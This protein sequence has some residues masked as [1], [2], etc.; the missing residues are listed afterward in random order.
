[1]GKQEYVQEFKKSL[2]II[3]GELNDLKNEVKKNN[4]KK[5]DLSKQFSIINLPSGGIYYPNRNKSLLIRYLTSVEEHILCDSLLMESGKGIE[6]VLDNLIM[7]D[8]DIRKLLVSDFQALLIFL[9]ST[10][11]GDAVSME[12]TCP[13]C[14]RSDEYTVRLSALKFK[15]PKV[16]PNENGKY[17]IFF[18][19]INV[20]VVTC[21]L[22]FEKELEKYENET[23]DDFFNLKNEDGEKIKIKKEKTLSLVYNIESI[24]GITDKTRIKKLVKNLPR[25]H[26]DYII[27]FIKE[28]EVGIEEKIT[29]KC[30]SCTEDFT[31]TLSV[32]YNFLSL[33]ESYKKD[34][35]LEESFLSTY[36]GKGINYTD[37]CAMPVFVRKFWCN[38]ISE[39]NRKQNENERREYDKAKSKKGKF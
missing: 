1:M 30:L 15:E 22:T 29:L 8:I 6:L 19:D 31:Q 32:G 9:R 14:A 26:M 13:H 28:N 23:D 2:D 34:G 21:P 10:S 20:E 16:H 27:D 11:Y 36:Y 12:M 5:P 25:K 35:V 7:D 17:V 4:K 39:E 38:R 3:I 33:P 37:V 18:E 24:N